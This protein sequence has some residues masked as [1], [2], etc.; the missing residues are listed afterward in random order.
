MTQ[1]WSYVHCST[2][3]VVRPYDWP[4]RHCGASPTYAF[5]SCPA[6][7]SHKCCAS[8]PPPRIGRSLFQ[9]RGTEGG[10]VILSVDHV[11][12]SHM[13]PSFSEWK[14]SLAKL[15]ISLSLLVTSLSSASVSFTS[16]RL[17]ERLLT[18]LR[19]V[20]V[21]KRKPRALPALYFLWKGEWEWEISTI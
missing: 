7:D 4:Q 5:P 3:V 13:W 19:P 14:I 18:E 11:A 1:S 17:A 16:I 21:R 2:P 6:Q 12:Q 8:S 10:Q 9:G 15:P 20:L